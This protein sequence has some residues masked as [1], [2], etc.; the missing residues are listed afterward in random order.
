MTFLDRIAECNAFDI[1]EFAPLFIRGARLGFVRRD[2]LRHFAERRGCTVDETGVRVDLEPASATSLFESIR[3]DLVAQGE[4][5]EALGER[6]PVARQFGSDP[7]ADV[8]RS[9]VAWLGVTA[10]G[11]HVNGFVR[12]DDV[13]EM[14]VAV[15][16]AGKLTFPGM[17]DNMVAGGQP[18]GFSPDHNVVK[19]CHE[20]AGIPREMAERAARVSEVSYC[21][22]HDRGLKPDTMFC[23]DLELP[24]EFVPTPVDGEVERFELWPIDRVAAR[25]RDTADF[26]FNCN[27]VIIDFLVRHGWIDAAADDYAAIVA[28]LRRA[29]PTGG[30]R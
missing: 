6:F 14:W 22:Q 2:R 17:L 11:V 4:L 29:V 26:K 15:R 30:V 9:M 21:V 23:Y 28:G 16:A 10:H 13:I 8:D 1:G 19:E 5:P 20:E 12:E 24:A 18:M 3:R 27:L 25:V 7:F